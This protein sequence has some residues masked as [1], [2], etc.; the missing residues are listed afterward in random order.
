LLEAEARYLDERGGA[1]T[2]SL[3]R[4]DVALVVRGLPVRAL[5]S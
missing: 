2:A 3:V 4:V 1:V 5:P